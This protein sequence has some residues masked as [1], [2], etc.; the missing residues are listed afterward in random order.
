VASGVNTCWSS[1]INHQLHRRQEGLVPVGRLH[2]DRCNRAAS[3]RW[4]VGWFTNGP[5]RAVIQSHFDRPC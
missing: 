5:A 4:L 2:V 3:S 1:W